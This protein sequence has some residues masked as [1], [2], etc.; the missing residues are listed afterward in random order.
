[1][2][3]TKAYNNNGRAC[4]D[5]LEL[6]FAIIFLVFWDVTLSVPSSELDL[7]IRMEPWPWGSSR[8]PEDGEDGAGDRC[9]HVPL[10]RWSWEFQ[11][12]LFTFKPTLKLFGIPPLC[13]FSE[14]DYDVFEAFLGA[15]VIMNNVLIKLVVPKKKK[16]VKDWRK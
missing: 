12:H 15:K 10:G 6:I 13:D 1:M 16:S 3:E 14:R 5:C 11:L 2:V 7:G 4:F 9:W 8:G